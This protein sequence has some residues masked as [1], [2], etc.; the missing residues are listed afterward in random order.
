MPGN[1]D[2]IIIGSGAGGGTLARSLA[3]TGKRI[4][5]LERGDWL[6][7]EAL[8]WDPK[9]VFVDNRYISPDTWY[10]SDGKPFQPQVHYFVGGAT[11]MYG[12]ALS[13]RGRTSANC[14]RRY[15]RTLAGLAYPLRGHGALLYTGRA[16]VSGA[17]RPRCGP[18]RTP[19]EC[20]ISLST[21][22]P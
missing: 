21:R 16:D 17:R 6:K 22:I 19:G 14:T 18:D 1:Y 20:T 3:I 8:N 12:A 2:V 5:I 4:L 13:L 10:G 9:A 15:R 7:R 11:K